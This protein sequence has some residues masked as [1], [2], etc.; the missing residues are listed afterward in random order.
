MHH[1]HHLPSRDVHAEHSIPTLIC[2]CTSQ[3]EKVKNRELKNKEVFGEVDCPDTLRNSTVGF[4]WWC[5]PVFCLPGAAQHFT[6]PGPPRPTFS[7]G[8]LTASTVPMLNMPFACHLPSIIVSPVA[9]PYLVNKACSSCLFPYWFTIP[10][11][12]KGVNAVKGKHLL[13]DHSSFLKVHFI[14]TR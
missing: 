5:S 3:T 12:G 14:L 2:S 9:L 11:M 4:F 6:A 1:H 7:A 10:C 13:G 8:A